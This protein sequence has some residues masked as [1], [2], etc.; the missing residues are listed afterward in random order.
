M[1]GG[2]GRRGASD[3]APRPLLA[4]VAR[5]WPSRLLCKASLL[6]AGKDAGRPRARNAP[7]APSRRPSEAAR[8]AAGHPSLRARQ[9]QA[10]KECSR[11][12]RRG[13]GPPPL[14]AACL[15]GVARRSPG[16]SVRGPAAAAAAS[17]PPVAAL[18][19]GAGVPELLAGSPPGAGGPPAQR[20]PWQAA[21]GLGLGQRRQLRGPRAALR[22]RPRRGGCEGSDGLTRCRRR[23]RRRRKALL[24]RSP[25]QTKAQSPGLSG[26]NGQPEPRSARSP[27]GA[28]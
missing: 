17:P 16:L 13:V 15:R 14:P 20:R 1:R 21:A 9:P 5:V 18:L 12:P 4:S 8:A 22:G 6:L 7:P 26:L 19:D 28:C 2:G 3:K 27:A 25:G 10:P 11:I 24:T 23:R